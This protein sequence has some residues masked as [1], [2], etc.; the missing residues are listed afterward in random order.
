MT[1]PQLRLSP[2][3]H[4]GLPELL[5]IEHKSPLRPCGACPSRGSLSGS[6]CFLLAGGRPPAS[7]VSPRAGRPPCDAAAQYDR[8]VWW[9]CGQGCSW[10]G[11]PGCGLPA[12]GLSPRVNGWDYA[13]SRGQG[14][15]LQCDF[16]GTFCAQAGGCTFWSSCQGKPLDMWD[17]PTGVSRTPSVPDACTDPRLAQASLTCPGVSHPPTPRA[18]GADPGLPVQETQEPQFVSIDHTPSGQ[19]QRKGPDTQPWIHLEVPTRTPS[20]ESHY[21]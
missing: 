16:W 2:R 19:Q 5:T 8:A 21:G 15:R 7:E 11:R 4:D 10:H 6:T 12:S 17:R 18:G 9:V 20:Q 13:H 3:V 14:S 1:P